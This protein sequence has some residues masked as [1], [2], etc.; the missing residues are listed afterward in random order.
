MPSASQIDFKGFFPIINPSDLGELLRD[1]IFTTEAGSEGLEGYM[2]F[3]TIP[4]SRNWTPEE[5]AGFLQDVGY[6]YDPV[7]DSVFEGKDKTIAAYNL[8]I[9]KVARVNTFTVFGVSIVCASHR[10][11][12]TVLFFSIEDPDTGYR[13][14]IVNWDSK[15]KA[16]ENLD[17]L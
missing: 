15:K 3:E 6:L 13:R 12:D 14:T 2:A 4:V 11:G 7:E 10:A 9:A 8:N 16:W 17:S 5:K 1:A